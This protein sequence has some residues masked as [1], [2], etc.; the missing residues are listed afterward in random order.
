M[1]GLEGFFMSSKEKG[2][3]EP[4]G[5]IISFKEKKL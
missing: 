1:V 3:K 4:W 5:A 2:R